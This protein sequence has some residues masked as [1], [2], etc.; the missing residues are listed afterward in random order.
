MTNAASAAGSSPS[1]AIPRALPKRAESLI[2]LI[3]RW[4]GH[5]GQL[6]GTDGAQCR[7]SAIRNLE[8]GGLKVAERRSP[9]L[10]IENLVG[11][12]AALRRWRECHEER[13]RS[14]PQ[15]GSKSG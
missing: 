11:K 9:A 6:Q 14:A 15:V 7:S 12:P 8:S 3:F 5:D 13:H 1:D 2:I 4:R 10:F